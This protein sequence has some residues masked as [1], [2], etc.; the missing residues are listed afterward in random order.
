MAEKKTT[1]ATETDAT[2]D[3]PFADPAPVEPDATGSLSGIAPVGPT[4]MDGDGQPDAGVEEG[5]AIK[6]AYADEVKASEDAEAARRE[7]KGLTAEGPEQRRRVNSL[8]EALYPDEN[9]SD[10][11][12]EAVAPKAD[13]AHA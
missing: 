6:D 3:D 2:S 7:A 9:V 5:Q 1:K 8:A 13:A 11:A 10:E 12:K 4:D